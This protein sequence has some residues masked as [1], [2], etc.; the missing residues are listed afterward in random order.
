M[1]K[2][3][4]M[5]IKDISWK[6]LSVFAAIIFWFVGM[7]V[8]DPT[9]I[10]DY[11]VR[12]TIQNKDRVTENGFVLANERELESTTINVVFRGSRSSLA[13]LSQ[14]QNDIVASIDLSP[15]DISNAKDIGAPLTASVNVTLPHNI[16]TN[17]LERIGVYP[18][19][20]NVRL[21]YFETVEI[22]IEAVVSGSLDDEYTALPPILEPSVVSI[23]GARTF[24]DTINTARVDINLND[25]DATGG[26]TEYNIT[27]PLRI[28]DMQG[29]PVSGISTNIS[30]VDATIPIRISAQIPISTP[31]IRGVVAD[32]HQM[33][34]MTISPNEV[35]VLGTREDIDAVR[36]IILDPI[37]IDGLSR[38]KQV[39][40][41]LRGYLLDTRLI[42]KEGS[43]IETVVNIS[44]EP[45]MTRDFF[46]AMSNINVIAE[47]IENISL[48]ESVMI[49]VRGVQSII[50][51]LTQNNISVSVDLTELPDYAGTHHV[52]LIINTPSRLTV[53]SDPTIAVVVLEHETVESEE[54][55]LEV[56]EHE[57]LVSN[58]YDI[59]Y[60]EEDYSEYYENEISAEE[61]YLN[62]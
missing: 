57:E 26:I 44:I 23:S 12:L 10:G 7:N 47:D 31:A 15:I 19:T 41:D 54:V 24:I 51:T 21:D 52:D 25:I 11:N 46:F 29:N 48:P 59:Y 8:Y 36:S 33:T 18:S 35:H 55:A 60:D 30:S 43:P 32:G 28:L 38:S 56:E 50:R 1:E 2:I 49:S 9:R 22:N 42:I 40:Y 27:A 53:V 6:M 61:D 3:Y 5:F 16:N 17:N 39:S 4:N 13:T 37:V 45:L 14:V 62:G 20:V 34:N 58:A